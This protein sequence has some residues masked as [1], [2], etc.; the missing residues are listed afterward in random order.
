M[1]A[2]TSNEALNATLKQ[3]QAV[4][5]GGKRQ[6]ESVT[7]YKVKV[8][9]ALA[10]GI[11]AAQGE[12]LNRKMDTF[13]VIKLVDLIKSGKWAEDVDSI[14]I[15]RGGRLVD[16]QHR[17][18]AVVVADRAVTMLIAMGVP[19]DVIKYIDTGKRRT[20]G[21]TLQILGT[22]VPAIRL[23]AANLLAHFERLAQ[24]PK[25]EAVRITARFPTL[26][27]DSV[28]EILERYEP[29]LTAVNPVLNE[30]NAAAIY[31]PLAYAAA[32]YPEATQAAMDF[33][34]DGQVAG[35]EILQRFH[36]AQKRLNRRDLGSGT[37][38]AEAEL[39]VL[40]L[41]R[42]LQTGKAPRQ[43]VRVESDAQ[44]HIDLLAFFTPAAK[45][46]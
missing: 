9:P 16:G 10:Q 19:D 20:T 13:N 15:T 33:I 23:A 44:E 35:S 1:Q 39:F 2:N 14:K 17:L 46:N 24:L 40:D 3:L 37:D 21:Q 25:T 5:V 34:R 41:V 26:D 7:Y 43:L 31:A 4:P 36:G 42:A 45:M 27:P 22:K 28:T 32:K 29:Q 38:R 6:V 11:L 8:T 12:N 30:Y 18:R